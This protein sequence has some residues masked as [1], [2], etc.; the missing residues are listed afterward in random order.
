MIRI[1]RRVSQDGTVRQHDLRTPHNCDRNSC[2][3]PLVE[4]DQVL[5]TLSL[6]PLTPYQF[7]VGGLGPYVGYLSFSRNEMPNDP[8]GFLYDRRHSRR[9]LEARWGG[10]PHADEEITTCVRKFGR[11]SSQAKYEALG[12]SHI[13]GVRMSSSNGHEVCNL[14]RK[15]IFFL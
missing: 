14:C 12:Q 15:D 2:P 6:S 1:I 10:L 4:L 8:Q 3:S 13:T 9:A 5:C 11:K 7:V